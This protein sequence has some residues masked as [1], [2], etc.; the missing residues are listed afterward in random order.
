MDTE[1]A[2]GGQL[3][4]SAVVVYTQSS[5]LPL[6]ACIFDELN[7]YCSIILLSMILEFL[8][9]SRVQVA[10]KNG[11]NTAKPQT[12]WSSIRQQPVNR[13]QSFLERSFHCAFV[14]VRAYATEALLDSAE[15]ESMLSSFRRMLRGVCDGDILLDSNLQIQGSP[16]TWAK[17][18]A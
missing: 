3:L 7:I 13:S 1:L 10:S 11:Q 8:L 6:A 12:K 2:V 17:L 15:A 9:Q 16:A 4:I 18:L 14:C 5:V